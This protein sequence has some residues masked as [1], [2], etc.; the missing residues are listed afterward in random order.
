MEAGNRAIAQNLIQQAEKIGDRLE[1]ASKSLDSRIALLEKS[2]TNI[3]QILELQERLDKNLRSIARDGHIEVVLTEIR[4]HLSE[5][6]PLLKQ[7]N[8]PRRITLVETE[9]KIE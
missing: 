5:L 2:K 8:K 4:E 6:K 3:A 7:L 1:H 9:D